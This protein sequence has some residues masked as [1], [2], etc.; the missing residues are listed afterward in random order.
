ML[1]A[2]VVGLTPALTTNPNEGVGVARREP[3][4]LVMVTTGGVVSTV[5]KKLATGPV[6]PRS[7]PRCR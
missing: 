2:V 5:K 4:G 6:L 1:H 3:V 7:F